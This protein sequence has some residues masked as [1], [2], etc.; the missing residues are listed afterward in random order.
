MYEKNILI[1]GKHADYMKKLVASFDG[2]LSQGIFIRNLDVYLLAPI[3][4]VI[5]GRRAKVD[6]D[7]RDIQPT[8]IHTEQLNR[9]MDQLELNYRILMMIIS[10]EI[11]NTET[12]INRAFRYDRDVE[13]RKDGDEIFEEFVLGGIEVLFEK[14]L[15]NTSDISDYLMRLHSFVNEFY[16]N[17]YN[18]LDYE[19]IYKLCKLSNG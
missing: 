9:E 3:V 15:E 5:Y 17:F 14:L 18:T 4:G 19:N 13:R 10:K 1:K 11:L 16:L 7:S 2:S 12:R 8:S 6:N